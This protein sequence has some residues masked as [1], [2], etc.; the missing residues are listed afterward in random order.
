MRDRKDS[1]IEIVRFPGSAGQSTNNARFAKGRPKGADIAADR[2]QR[3][4]AAAARNRVLRM[5][6]MKRLANQDPPLLLS[7]YDDIKR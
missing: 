2:Q 6:E 4:E 7:A 5:K 3:N 1:I